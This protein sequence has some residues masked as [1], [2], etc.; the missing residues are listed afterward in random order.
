M[1]K[2]KGPVLPPLKIGHGIY[3]DLLKSLAKGPPVWPPRPKP[4][5]PPNQD[6]IFLSDVTFLNPKP[7]LPNMNSNPGTL[8]HNPKPNR[9]NKP[10][11]YSNPES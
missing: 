9:Q 3:E 2:L 5:N 7:S 1:S 10:T 11:L 6:C 4:L 8:A